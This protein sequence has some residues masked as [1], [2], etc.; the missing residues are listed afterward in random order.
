MPAGQV[1]SLIKDLKGISDV[2]PEM[3]R[4]AEIISSRLNHFFREGGS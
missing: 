1:A 3:V 2:F 4:E